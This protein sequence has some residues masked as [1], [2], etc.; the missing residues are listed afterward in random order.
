MDDSRG[1]IAGTSFENLIEK[2]RNQSEP[3]PRPLQRTVYLYYLSRYLLS[4]YEATFSE[5]PDQVLNE[6]RNGLDHLMRFL[7]SG[8]DISQDDKHRNLSKMEGH[9][10]RALLDLCKH[11]SYSMENWVVEF[12]RDCG[13]MEVL[14]LISNGEFVRKWG[15]MRQAIHDP[16]MTAK[17]EDS[18]LGEDASSND[19]IVKQYLSVA[20]ACRQLRKF[21]ESNRGHVAPAMRQRDAIASEG[22]NLSV[23]TQTKIA[24]RYAIYGTMLGGCV[25][26]IIAVIFN[27]FQ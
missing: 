22:K 1:D 10:Q 8:D 16:F 23:A 13:G 5:I 26:L 20:E 2:A 15:E 4:L 7:S 19:D 3:A 24:R 14:S 17:T 25:A 21:G 9:M 11:Y 27:L 18:Y 12:E 6:Y